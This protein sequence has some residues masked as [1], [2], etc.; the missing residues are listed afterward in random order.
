MS[1]WTVTFLKED[2]RTEATH[3][4]SRHYSVA[5][6]VCVVCKEDV[7]R[8]RNAMRNAVVPEESFKRL[9]ASFEM[10]KKGL[11]V[12]SDEMSQESAAENILERLEKIRAWRANAP[13]TPIAQA[14]TTRSTWPR[15]A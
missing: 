15:S 3:K 4:L 2:Y 8:A 13:G 11:V 7:A 6:V 14:S 9:S 12:H 10:P 5:V 1:Y